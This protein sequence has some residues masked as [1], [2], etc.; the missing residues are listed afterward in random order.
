M[1][2]SGHVALAILG[3]A[4]FGLAG[5]Q[6]AATDA[7][8]FPD[9]DSCLKAATQ[10][11]WFTADDCRTTFA[12]AELLHEETAPRYD[13]AALCEEQHGDGDLAAADAI[14]ED[15][16]GQAPHGAI[17]DGHGGDPAD[18]GRV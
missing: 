1:K 6:E 16:C 12:E 14:G 18:G 7:A 10:D 15:A 17:E 13:S 8:S 3:A 9:L 5:C 2:R 11:G 4:A